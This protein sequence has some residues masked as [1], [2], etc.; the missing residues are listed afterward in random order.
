[1]WHD[2]NTIDPLAKK[3]TAAEGAHWQPSFPFLLGIFSVTYLNELG[4][5][6]V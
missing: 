4:Y 3:K 5:E 6:H 1:M 2:K